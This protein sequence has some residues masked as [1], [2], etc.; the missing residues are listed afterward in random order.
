MRIF[1]A[2]FGTDESLGVTG[3]GRGDPGGG[4]PY[5]TRP[6]GGRLWQI[7]SRWAKLGPKEPGGGWFAHDLPQGQEGRDWEEERE[8]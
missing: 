1:G 5:C 7:W 6:S 8:A 2:S 3:K 4:S